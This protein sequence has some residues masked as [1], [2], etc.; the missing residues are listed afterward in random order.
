MVGKISKT[1]DNKEKLPRTEWRGMTERD[2]R[3]MRVTVSKT[4]G[5][6]GERGGSGRIKK[7]GLSCRGL[8]VVARA[9]VAVWV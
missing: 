8:T 4:D 7:H 6:E 5:K 3:G 9:T 2:N 1:A